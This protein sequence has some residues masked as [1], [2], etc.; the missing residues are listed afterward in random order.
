[1]VHWKRLQ[2][3]GKYCNKNVIIFKKGIA[4]CKLVCYNTVT[5]IRKKE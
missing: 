2:Y 4:I 5:Y 3:K 1:M